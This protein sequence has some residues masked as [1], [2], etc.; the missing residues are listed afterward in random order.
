MK[1]SRL[2]PNTPEWE[3]LLALGADEYIGVKEG[4]DFWAICKPEPIGV[5]AF[6]FIA[7][8]IKE[9]HF[10][11]APERRKRWWTREFY[12]LFLGIAFADADV[13]VAAVEDGSSS[14][15]LVMGLGWEKYCQRGRVSYHQITRKACIK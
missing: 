10:W 6:E 14:H 3:A 8:R 5:V 13:M 11:V 2:L 7:P 4:C 9:T 12:R 1:L 15:R